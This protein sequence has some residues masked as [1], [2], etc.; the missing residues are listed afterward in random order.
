[1]PP[2]NLPFV[3]RS[4]PANAAR[5]EQVLGGVPCG[6]ARNPTQSHLLSVD[7]FDLPTR[8]RLRREA[9]VTRRR[10]HQTSRLVTTGL[11][12]VAHDDSPRRRAFGDTES[13]PEWHGIMGCRVKPGNDDGVG[14]GEQHT[15][16][17]GHRLEVSLS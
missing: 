12:P 15:H 16:L 11:D 5:H 6:E 8:G 1:M 13:T 7:A 10:R 17:V 9:T 2:F 14:D 4:K 3:G